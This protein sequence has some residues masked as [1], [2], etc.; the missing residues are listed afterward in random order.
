M[1]EASS[2]I[3]SSKS[4]SGTPTNLFQQRPNIFQGNKVISQK[5]IVIRKT[6]F[7]FTREYQKYFISLFKEDAISN[8]LLY[9]L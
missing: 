4:P 3:Q 8:N 2:F 5:K 1:K 6:Y 9:V 7:L